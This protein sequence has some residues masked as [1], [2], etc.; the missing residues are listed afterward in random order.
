MWDGKPDKIKRTQMC[1]LNYLGGM[2]MVDLDKFIMSLNI[3]W[4]KRLIISDK[5]PWAVFFQETITN[6]YDIVNLGVIYINKLLLNINNIFWKTILNTWINYILLNQPTKLE[7]KL[8]MPIWYNHLLLKDNIFIKNWY[9]GGIIQIGDILDKSNKVLSVQEIVRKYNVQQIDFL[10]YHRLKLAIT[11]YLYTND[12]QSTYI[13]PNIPYTLI[14]LMKGRKGTRPIYRVLLPD[15]Q[16]FSSPKWDIDLGLVIDKNTWTDI[17][18]TCLFTLKDNYLSWFQMKIIYRILGTKQYLHKIK[19][20]ASP[21]CNLCHKN[22]QTLIHLFYEC[23]TTS[24]L[25]NDLQN[26][27]SNKIGINIQLTKCDIILGYLINNNFKHA[28]N[29]ILLVTKSYIF[30]SSRH[31]KSPNINQLQ[32][33]IK[34]TYSQQEIISKINQKHEQFE[35]SWRIWKTLI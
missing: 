21:T 5:Q 35:K 9:Q 2:N 12:P 31:D 13:K 18:N 14:P 22:P 19:F 34:S 20:I 3:S 17:F 10:T 24:I 25:L 32:S 28:L 27:I 16:F 6:K 4:I 15:K 33:W 7:H 1:Q 11:G 29:T 8:T 30:W 26:W 23:P